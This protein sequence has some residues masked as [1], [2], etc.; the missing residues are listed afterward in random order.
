MGTPQSRLSFLAFEGEGIPLTYT[1]ASPPTSHR[2]QYP[3]DQ[4]IV[5]M[6]GGAGSAPSAL[7]SEHANP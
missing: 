3:M 1:P 2:N 4:S 7:A 5:T 6:G